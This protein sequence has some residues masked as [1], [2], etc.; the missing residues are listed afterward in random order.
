MAEKM[1]LSL[2]LWLDLTQISLHVLLINFLG[3][4]AQHKDCVKTFKKLEKQP[5][6]KPGYAWL[7][8]DLFLFL[9]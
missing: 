5:K 6:Q 8:S 3:Q 2:R 1:S 9:V 4:H 7:E